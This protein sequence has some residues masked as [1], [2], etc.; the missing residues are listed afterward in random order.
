MSAIEE[1]VCASCSCLSIQCQLFRPGPLRQ[2]AVH[3]QVFTI[4]YLDPLRRASATFDVDDPFSP[5][6]LQ[7]TFAHNMLCG[8]AV[9]CWIAIM[10]EY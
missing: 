7:E 1:L 2:P 3:F 10:L 4:Y 6:V 5:T 8:E 9:L